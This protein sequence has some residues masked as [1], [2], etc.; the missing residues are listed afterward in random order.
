MQLGDAAHSFLPT[1]GNGATQAVEDALSLSTCLRL[2]GRE[3]VVNSVRAHVKLRYERVSTL[4]RFGFANRQILH[5]VDPDELERNPGLMTMKMG[6]WIWTHDPVKYAR[7]NYRAA[8]DA[9]IHGTSFENTNLPPGHKFVPWTIAAELE[10]EEK[11][12]RTELM[13]TGDWS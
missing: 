7:E 3:N 1:S 12:L 13:D 9:V 5:Y 11:G 2:G 10:R 4:Q 6:R 8:L